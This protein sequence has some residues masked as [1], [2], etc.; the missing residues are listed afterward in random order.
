[1]TAVRIEPA[2]RTSFR[3]PEHLFPTGPPEARG[4][5]RDDV[6]LL[7]ARPGALEHRSFGDLPGVPAP[8]DLVVVNTSA[9]LPAAVDA[10]TDAGPAVVHFSMP[11]D[12]GTWTIE[13]RAPGGS[14][15][16]RDLAPGDTLALVG[17]GRAT[18][19]GPA[20]GSCPAGG[21]RLWRAAVDVPGGIERYLRRR[22]RPI[23]YGHSGTWPLA[24]Y[25]TIFAREPGSA[26]MPS[27]ARPFTHA[28]VGRMVTAGIRFASIVLHAGVSSLDAGEEPEPERYAVPGATAELVNDTRRAG[29]RVIA[30]GTTVVRALETVA[31]ENGEVAPGS[32]RT[33]LVL[34]PDR[35]TRAIDGLITGWHLPEASHLLLLEAFAGYGLVQAAY[36]EALAEGYLWHEFGDSCLFL[37]D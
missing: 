30:V 8:G 21:S 2:A 36:G 18:L 17:G 14:H 6:R 37:R 9:T 10:I 23:S 3:V 27:A 12:D 31:D 33:T 7:V 22:G 24:A 25:Q 16:R 4:R 5:G 35:A 26:E 11:L 29:G 32:G 34:G 15:G 28:L 20:Y 13:V 19:D 1:M